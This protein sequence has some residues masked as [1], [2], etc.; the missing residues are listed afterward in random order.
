M[1]LIHLKCVI[2]TPQHWCFLDTATSRVD[3][4]SQLC[5]DGGLRR[6][7]VGG[8]GGSAPTAMIRR[9]RRA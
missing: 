3:E 2:D 4:K 8:G 1:I 6:I 7:V 5:H 9:R